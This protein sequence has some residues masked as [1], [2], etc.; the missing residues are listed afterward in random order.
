LRLEEYV[1]G[2]KRL[3]ALVERL[4]PGVLAL[5]GITVYRRLQ[6]VRGAVELGLQDDLVHGA[7]V[8]VLPNPS[9]RN[10]HH[11]YAAMLR[12]FRALKRE[13][14][15]ASIPA[16]RVGSVSARKVARPGLGGGE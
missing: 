7:R 15:H 4:R 6:G 3:L 12:A 16:R 2:R 9:G 5:V 8:F 10:A 11:S 13:L 14:N 1:A